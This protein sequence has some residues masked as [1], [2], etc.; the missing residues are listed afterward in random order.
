MII[1]G[2]GFQAQRFFSLLES[3]NLID[4]IH[5]F[6]DSNPEKWGNEFCGRKIESPEIFRTK[7]K[8]ITIVIAVSLVSGS[9]DIYSKL[10]KE[11]KINKNQI[12][13]GLFFLD[14]TWHSLPGVLEKEQIGSPH[15]YWKRTFT[16]KPLTKYSKKI[17][18]K[19]YLKTDSYT[20]NV[21]DLLGKMYLSKN[22]YDAFAGFAQ[23]QKIKNFSENHFFNEDYFSE[24]SFKNENITLFDIG[25]YIGD[26]WENFATLF[27]NNLKKI[28]A[29]EPDKGSFGRAQT[30]AIKY[31]RYKNIVE[32][33]NLAL[34]NENN[35]LDNMPFKIKG[36]IFM[37]LD[38]EG[39]E[40]D[41]LKGATKMIKKYKPILAVCV[42]HY[43]DD[44]WKIPEYL[45]SIVPEYKFVLRGGAHL[46]C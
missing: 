21:F 34:D 6:V 7:R 45:K 27:R 23:Y 10:I 38:V 28:Y 22:G 42:Y 17:F 44:I 13:S 2:T 4:E 16:K 29:F 11:Y 19:N 36:K 32:C 35:K 12:Y 5:G 9:D 41:I 39:A 31:N 33:F 37:K 1:Y 24:I 14:P 30:R 15:D 3:N 8:D 40:M 26:S 25:A 18:C 20:K 43:I 46:V